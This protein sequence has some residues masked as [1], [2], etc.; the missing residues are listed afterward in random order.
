MTQPRKHPSSGL[1]LSR[2]VVS[3]KLSLGLS[4]LGWLGALPVQAAVEMR[5][6]VVERLDRVSV[7]SSTPAIVKNTAGQGI[8]QI[9]QGRSVVV[10]V[11]G[12]TLRL[13]DWQGQAFWVEPANGGHVFINNTWYR[14]RVLVMPVEG[15]V[16]A[17]NWV[18][19]EAYLYSVLGAEMPASWPQEALKAQAVAARSYALYQRD[20]GAAN[21]FDVG[22]TT[23]HQVYKGLASEAPSTVAA[24]NATRGQVLTYGGRVIEAV[25]HASSGGRTENVEDVWQKPVPYLRSVPDFD[26]DAPVYRWSETFSTSQFE[27]RVR[28]VG[29]L[30]AVSIERVT[31]Q[32]RVV[33]LRLQGTQGTRTLSGTELR[34]ALGLRSTLFSISLQGDTIRVDGRGFGH[35][36]GMSQWGARG[37]ALQGYSYAQILAHYYLGAVLSQIQVA[38]L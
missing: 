19:L 1:L 2:F 36:L 30:R 8:G 11:A 34:Q 24:V 13:A 23:A 22:S 12:G 14:G 31:P 25:F 9:P 33:S 32:G 37:L 4:C 7:G 27:Q 16:T 28:G 20:R 5:V 29:R 3:L 17:I 6:A 18:D 38:G 15:K 21:A 10:T 26:Q 35:G